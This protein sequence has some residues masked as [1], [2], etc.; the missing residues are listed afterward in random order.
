MNTLRASYI[1]YVYRVGGWKGV[2]QDD[3]NR[4]SG[5]D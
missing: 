5:D 1:V 4:G 2:M 3:G